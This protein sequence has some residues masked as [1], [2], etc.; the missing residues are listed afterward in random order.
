MAKAVEE[1]P[2]TDRKVP[3]KLSK[4]QKKKLAEKKRK[5]MK[6]MKSSI[7]SDDITVEG[8]ATMAS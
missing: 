4:D 2:L 5:M 8:A 3:V 6:R 1:A 7:E